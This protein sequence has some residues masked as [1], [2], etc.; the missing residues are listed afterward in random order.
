MSSENQN[1][2]PKNPL[3]SPQLSASEVLITYI[4]IHPRIHLLN[5]NDP[6]MKCLVRQAMRTFFSFHLCH[7]MTNCWKVK[8]PLPAFFF[9]RYTHWEIFKQRLLGSRLGCNK[10]VCVQFND[11]MLS[12]KLTPSAHPL[13][14]DHVNACASWMVRSW[15]FCRSLSLRGV[16]S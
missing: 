7:C 16:S 11:I 6:Q 5:N 14:P 10:G 4:Q 9:C 12:G 15:W 3:K 1:L 8:S 13:S 2:K